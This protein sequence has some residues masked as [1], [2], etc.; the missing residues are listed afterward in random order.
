M[1]VGVITYVVLCGCVRYG[2]VLP[3]NLKIKAIFYHIICLIASMYISVYG[4]LMYYG[5]NSLPEKF[6]QI[7]YGIHLL[8]IIVGI[9]IIKKLITNE[10][11]QENEITEES[12][13]EEA[14]QIRKSRIITFI[15]GFI[16]IVIIV[17]KIFSQLN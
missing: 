17:Y 2:F 9:I 14:E 12:A 6:D 10:Y 4:P 1:W 3:R 16:L 8:L 7:V 15:L 5:K 13:R 11:L